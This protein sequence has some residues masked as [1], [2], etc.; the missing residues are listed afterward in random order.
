MINRILDDFQSKRAFKFKEV[1]AFYEYQPEVSPNRV[2][3]K[4]EDELLASILENHPDLIVDF[5][6]HDSLLEIV[7]DHDLTEEEKLQA[8][9]EWESD[10]QL[11]EKVQKDNMQKMFLNGVGLGLKTNLTATNAA[12][13]QS[14]ATATSQAHL[15]TRLDESGPTANKA[16]T[17]T[18]SSGGQQTPGTSLL[19]PNQKKSKSIEVGSPAGNNQEGFLLNLLKTPLVTSTTSRNPQTVP[20]SASNPFGSRTS[21]KATVAAAAAAQHPLLDKLS[22]SK[23]HQTQRT[24][25]SFRPQ[26]TSTNTTEYFSP[27]HNQQ[28]PF[29]NVA[30]PSASHQPQANTSQQPSKTANPI[31]SAANDQTCFSKRDPRLQQ[32]ANP[33]ANPNAN[34]AANSAANSSFGTPPPPKNARV[35]RP[36]FHPNFHPQSAG[37]PINQQNINQ[38]Q[39][40]PQFVNTNIPNVR[41]AYGVPPFVGGQPGPNA[42]MNA[43]RPASAQPNVNFGRPTNV[44]PNTSR[45]RNVHS[46]VNAGGSTNVPTNGPPNAGANR[47]MNPLNFQRPTILIQVVNDPKE[48]EEKALSNIKTLFKNYEKTCAP[49]TGIDLVMILSDRLKN[50]QVRARQ[51]ERQPDS[52]QK[53]RESFIIKAEKRLI[54]VGFTLFL[55]NSIIFD[56][57]DCS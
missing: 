55:N 33:N 51:L 48:I 6:E 56:Q 18:F 54:D 42:Q 49:T 38:T 41:M 10:K 52:P 53:L 47:P 20:R 57:F 4:P 28:A 25:S 21:P 46:N 36:L 32:H 3:K 11:K 12:N 26:Q 2:L 35:N 43:N 16:T 39:F 5:H 7:P 31:P 9:H 1:K 29:A 22:P 13:V 44:P 24:Y 34:S 15:R 23:L 27:N 40:M 37:Q 30:Q 14:F 8:W 17:P 50:I 19:N 45:T